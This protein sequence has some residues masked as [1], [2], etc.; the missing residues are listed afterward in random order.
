MMLF[1]DNFNFKKGHKY[2]F[3]I[4]YSHGAFLWLQ[5]IKNRVYKENA[6]IFYF[7]SAFFMIINLQ[8][9]VYVRF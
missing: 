7:Y 8:K 9:W 6:C 2:D 3:K 5:I 4:I 1:I